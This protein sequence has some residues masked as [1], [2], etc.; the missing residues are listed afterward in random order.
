MVQKCKCGRKVIK[1][2][3]WK[4]QEEGISLKESS[5]IYWLNWLKIDWFSILLILVII[6]MVWGYKVDMQKCEAAIER[7]CEFCDTT[8]CCSDWYKITNRGP[9]IP[10]VRLDNVNLSES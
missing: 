1:F 2:P 6:L 10:P 4:N 8:G 3:L 5:K 9:S 7:P